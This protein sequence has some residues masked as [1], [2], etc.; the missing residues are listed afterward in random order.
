MK[1]KVTVRPITKKT[2]LSFAPLA[3]R[4]ESRSIL[5][6]A[7]EAVGFELAGAGFNG[8]GENCRLLP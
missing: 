6:I 3:L 7:H 5:L 2:K 1:V 4:I 8:I